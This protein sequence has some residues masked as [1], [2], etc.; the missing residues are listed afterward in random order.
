VFKAKGITDQLPSEMPYLQAIH[1]VIRAKPG[2]HITL[3]GAEWETDDT[4][5]FLSP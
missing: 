5:P 3:A 2:L 4:P 1:K